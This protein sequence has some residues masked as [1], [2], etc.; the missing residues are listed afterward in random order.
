MFLKWRMF[1]KWSAC[2][3]SKK[4]VGNNTYANVTSFLKLLFLYTAYVDNRSIS[5]TICI[6]IDLKANEM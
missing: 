1:L 6:I 5:N 4:S 2:K 3:Q